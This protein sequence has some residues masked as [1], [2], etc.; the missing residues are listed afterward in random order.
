MRRCG[1]R[2][3]LPAPLLLYLMA[4]VLQPLAHP[5]LLPGTVI[6]EGEKHLQCSFVIDAP[7][8]LLVAQVNGRLAARSFPAL[9]GASASLLSSTRAPDSV[10]GAI[11]EFVV[12]APGDFHVWVFEQGRRWASPFRWRISAG[13]WH[14][15]PSSLP[16]ERQLRLAAD[17]P[18]FAWC[19]L[20]AVTLGAGRHRLEV[21]VSGPREDGRYLLAQDC[22]ALVSLAQKDEGRPFEYRY[23]GPAAGSLLLWDSAAPHSSSECGFLPWMDAYLLED[24]VV[25]GAVIVFPGGAYVGR[26]PS[27]GVTVARRFNREGFHSFVVYYRTAPHRHP[28]PLLDAARA[29]RIVRSRSAQLRV[30]PTRIAVCGFSAGGHLCATLGVHFDKA[31]RD[32]GDTIDTVSARPDALVLCYPVISFG[33]HGHRGSARNLLGEDPSD[34]LIALLSLETQVTKNTPPAFLWHTAPDDVKVENSLLFASALGAHKVPFE[35][36]VFHRGPHGMNLAEG[37]ARVGTWVTLCAGWLT[38]MGWGI[39]G[40][41]Q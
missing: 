17:G 4:M 23:E 33:R 31:N 25:R 27:E 6:I 35:V 12:R 36:H 28:A 37:D 22:F 1:L 14:E 11:Y 5:V 10:Y 39:H 19:R 3:P 30:D 16:T 18:T 15:A 8:P 41:A 29:V 38:E 9:S 32:G 40:S 7:D 26:A 20:G 24:A 21:Q 13:A 2:W 34:S